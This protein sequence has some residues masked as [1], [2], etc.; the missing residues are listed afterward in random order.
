MRTLLSV[1]G[2]L[3]AVAGTVP[4]I[5]ETIRGNTKPRVVTWLTWALLTGI[6]GAASLSAG[7]LGAAVFAL[8]G[9]VATSSVVVAGLRYGD[10]SFTRL[11]LACLA[12]V[13][14]GLVLWLSLDNPIFAIWTAILIDFVGLV[15]TLVH[16]W[17]QPMAE[18]ASAFVCV[19][20]GGLITSAA[21]ASGGSFSVA[22]LGYPLYAA[23]SMATVA[24]IIVIRRKSVQPEVGDTVAKPRDELS[25][26]LA[27]TRPVGDLRRIGITRPN[28]RRLPPMTSRLVPASTERDTDNQRVG[29]R[30]RAKRYTGRV[31]RP[32]R[33]RLRRATVR[34]RPAVARPMAPLAPGGQGIEKT[35]FLVIGETGAVRTWSRSGQLPG[36]RV[37]ESMRK[38]AGME[39]GGD[40]TVGVTRVHAVPVRIIQPQRQ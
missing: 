34:G 28:L 23:V 16:A 21:I 20:V 30:R 5:I 27:A 2:S 9:T 40:C 15:P 22:A 35:P 6:A 11:D 7:Q 10:R 25:R 33:V 3:I 38:R 13:L 1:L 29:S 18:T 14:L 37:G 8:L 17:K 39:A 26:R 32:R 24:S 4:Y 19:G 36:Q 12:G 31:R